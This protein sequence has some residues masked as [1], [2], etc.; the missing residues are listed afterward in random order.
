MV[1]IEPQAINVSVPDDIAQWDNVSLGAPTTYG[2][3]PTGATVPG[4]NADVTNLPYQ[5]PC[6]TNAW[7]YYPINVSANTQI[8]PGSSGKNVYGCAVLM[9]GQPAAVNVNFVESSTSGNACATS[10]VGMMGGATAAL[11]ANMAANGGYVAMPPGNRALM[12]TATAG[13]AVC[14]FTSGQA[15]GV[16]AYVQ[17]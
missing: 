1:A 16:F 11:G 17:Q 6:T 14:I 12:K 8:V 2:T 5:D 13:D 3:A 4:V 10:P 7:I 15:T 9:P